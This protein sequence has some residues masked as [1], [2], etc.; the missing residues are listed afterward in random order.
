MGLGGDEPGVFRDLHH[1]HDPSVRGQPAERH[2]AGFQVFPVI[3]VYFI[4]V[5]VAFADLCGV[6]EFFGQG[7]LFQDAG[8]CA[9][10]EGPADVFHPDLVFHDV[11][12][13]V[14]GVVPEF[15]A[16][17]VVPA[18]H[19]PGEFHDGQLHAQADPEERD[20]AGAGVPDGGDHALDAAASEPAG[21]KDA[22]DV[23][24]EPVRVL[25]GYG[26]GVDP[27]DPDRGVRVDAAVLQRFNDA[28]IGVVE[29]G[30]FPD[31]G[32]RYILGRMPQVVHHLRP[33][34][35]VRFRTVQMQAF[36]DDLGQAFFFHCQGRFIEIFH[37]QVLEDVA[38]RNV[39]EEGDLV[40]H[41]RAQR[42]FGPADDDVG[43][44][45]HALEFFYAGL[46]RFGLHFLGRFQVGDQRHVDEDH[47][48]VPFLMAELPDGLQ[49]RL[50]FNVAD[51]A[52]HFDDGDLGIFGGRIAVEAALDLVCDVGDH[53]DGAAA[54]VAAPFFLED[55]PVDLSCGNVGILRQVLIDEP[56][57]V[58]QVQIGLGA[59]V[60]D[61]DFAVLDR[62]HGARVDVDVGIEFLHGHGV[63]SGLQQTAEGSC[64]DAFPQTGYNASCDEYIFDC[65]NKTSCMHMLC[66]KCC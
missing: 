47:I 21:D 40:F 59:V 35:K 11:D 63:S 39:A 27:F 20:A 41:L 38:G 64:R 19:I 34:I 48:F 3:I 30:V 53:L 26:F 1:F 49:E 36:T 7:S 66:G 61:K 60:G 55:G 42:I 29:L 28:D 51:G 52:A 56:F 17:G 57:V 24:E 44:D 2:A 25:F 5:T 32:D 45:A 31:Q 9:Q 43:T 62:V 23:S 58:P 6:V 18:D 22:A 12:D 46:G 15:H 8:I 50:A 13:R 16:V 54:E 4:A 65:H 33:V 10:P 14:G 37:I